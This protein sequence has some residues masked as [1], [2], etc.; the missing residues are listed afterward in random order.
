MSPSAIAYITRIAE[1]ILSD[2]VIVDNR[3]QAKPVAPPARAD[4]ATQRCSIEGGNG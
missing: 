4:K 3:I 2:R 1:N